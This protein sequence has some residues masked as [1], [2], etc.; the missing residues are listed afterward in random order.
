MRMILASLPLFGGGFLWSTDADATTL[1]KLT[2]EQRVEIADQIV[3]GTV[4]EVWA[5]RDERGVIW[6][7]AQIEIARVYKGDE[8]YGEGGDIT[9]V[10]DQLGGDWAGLYNHVASASRFSVGE[11][12]VVCLQELESG[13]LVPVGMAQGKWT[14]RLDPYSRT[15]IVQRYAPPWTDTFD[16]RFIPLPAE[17]DR[18]YLDGFEARI[19]A[20]VEASTVEA[21]T[22]EASTVDAK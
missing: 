16:H 15:E 22:V 1:R 18:E 4:G 17:K 8:L 13:R 14:V 9:L 19:I 7:R 20:T 3:R 21:S 2:L 11:E 10:I 6:T 12:L 5:E